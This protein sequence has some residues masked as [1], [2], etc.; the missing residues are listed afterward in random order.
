MKIEDLQK[1]LN[2]M[3]NKE[4]TR[5]GLLVAAIIILAFILVANAR[6]G[7]KAITFKRI[8]EKGRAVVERLKTPA[9]RKARKRKPA[10]IQAMLREVGREDPFL[11]P[12]ERR[13]TVR[14]ARGALH[15][16]GIV[17]DGRR[18]LAIINDMLVG[19]GDMIEDKK[20][21]KIKSRSVVVRESGREYT[22]R[23]EGFKPQKGGE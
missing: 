21:I 8:G 7:R 15:L 14:P 18:S 2:K 10:E 9:E 12:S 11:K 4:K 23:L 5:L 20:I 17:S 22:L 13:A 16:S 1:K 19:E 6:R 3:S